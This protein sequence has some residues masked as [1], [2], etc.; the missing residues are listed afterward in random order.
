MEPWAARKRRLGAEMGTAPGVENHPGQIN[1]CCLGRE[2]LG[3]DSRSPPV[4]KKRNQTVK[5]FV[6]KSKHPL[7]ES[8]LMVLLILLYKKQ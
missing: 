6:H 1:S 5:E 2:N 8:K 4:E 3:G 7:A